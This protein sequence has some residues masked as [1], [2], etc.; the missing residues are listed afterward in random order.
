MAPSL[1]ASYNLVTSAVDSSTL[2]TPSFTP[3]NGEVIVVKAATWDSGTSMST[4][5]GGSQ[6]YTQ[7]VA[8]TVGGFRPYVAIWT[9]TVSG[10]PGS[11]TISSTPSASSWHN[12]VVERW[13]SAQLAA[14]PVTDSLQGGTGAASSTL[15]TT[16]ANSVISWVA[17]DAQSLNPATRAY[18]NGGTTTEELVDDQHVPTNGVWYY[19]RQSVAAAGS[20]SYGLSAPTPMQWWIAAV[21]ILDNSGAA[22]AVAT[23]PIV[24]TRAATRPVA[25]PVLLARGTLADPPVLTTRSPMVVG[26][27]PALPASTAILARNS[28]PA[29]AAPAASTSPPYVVTAPAP[30]PPTTALL[31]RSSLADTPVLTTASPLVV[32]TTPAVTRPAAILARAPQVPAVQ[33]PAATAQPTVVTV[34]TAPPPSTALLSRGTLADAP[35]LTTASPIVL[36]TPAR[37]PSAAAFLTRNPQPFIPPVPG[38]TTRPIVVTAVRPGPPGLTVLIRGA[39]G[40][41]DCLTHRPNAG[42]TTR[43]SSGITARPS[44]GTTTRTAAGTTT[45]PSAGVTT[46][47]CTCQGG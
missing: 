22:Q 9:A 42:I 44:S 45:R 14:T 10:S 38:P 35:V 5:T 29:A 31:L 17:G 2:T 41:C 8:S 25:Q 20:T 18:L 30:A 47:P 23:T 36:T 46:R 21:E 1:I 28:A 3:S 11:M 7:R 32:T 4:P 15:T 19:V 26:R 33:A 39:G 40:A 27:P 6:T 16:A 24:V 37:P 43:P 13:S 34:A 12:M